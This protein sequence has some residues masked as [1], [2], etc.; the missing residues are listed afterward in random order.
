MAWRLNVRLQKWLLSSRQWFDRQQRLVLT[1]SLSLL[2]LLLISLAL[3]GISGYLIAFIAA[4][5]TLWLGYL[6]VA[7]GDE[8]Q[9]QINTLSNLIE[10]MIEGDF[11]MRSRLNESQALN[12]ISKLLNQLAD[13]LLSQK[14]AAKESRLLLA[15]M[16]EQMD[17]MVLITNEQGFV[18]MSN[19]AAKRL[20]N[21]D[22]NGQ[23]QLHLPSHVKGKLVVECS[24]ELLILDSGPDTG[25]YFLFKDVFL[26]QGKQ[27]QLYII[28][29]ANR[30]LMEKERK[31][32]QGL[33]RVLSH[34]MN[35]SLTPIIG[36]SQQLQKKIA[37][38]QIPDSSQW[39]A[40]IA[41]ITERASSLS[42]F[43]GAY[44]ELTHLP[45]PQ[46]SVH[47]LSAMIRDALA[48]FPSLQATVNIEGAINI[49]VDKRQF[50]QVLVNVFKNAHE[51]MTNLTE[52]HL[53]IEAYVEQENLVLKIIDAGAGVKNPDNL[54]VPFYSTKPQGSG[55]GLALCRQILFNHHASIALSNNTNGRGACVTII[56][57][58]QRALP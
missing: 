15:R 18:V 56:F 6:V 35:N 26:N 32:W 20:F 3:L 38:A 49:H 5:F 13:T 27:H 21:V 11:S 52:K 29:D 17:A 36:I 53:T 45:P 24:S 40:G 46:K 47:S 31:A 12:D 14:V 8:T 9:Y 43:I 39:Q 16:L 44:S 30:L 34:E 2:V 22:A 54:F 55:I 23:N 7:I 41:I 1:F 57:N 28:R 51:A 4:V 19:Q 50:E 25:R 37:S 10:A 33:L 58:G 42:S 48:L